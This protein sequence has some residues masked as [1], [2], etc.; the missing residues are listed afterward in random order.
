LQVCITLLGNNIALERNRTVDHILTMDV[1]YQLSYKGKKQTT[2]SL[3]KSDRFG[4][5]TIAK[6]IP[7]VNN[8]ELIA[9]P[10]RFT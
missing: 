6:S 3:F 8:E 9:Y 5:G 2:P 4:S 1:L 10:Q 7:F